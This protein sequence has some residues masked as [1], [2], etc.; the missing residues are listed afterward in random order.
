MRNLKINKIDLLVK[1][2]KIS[3]SIYEKYNQKKVDEIV[4]AA[5]W[6][7]L[8][9]SN[10]IYLSKLAV[11][12]TGLGRTEDKFLK[13]RNK[14][15][16]LLR[17]LKNIKTVG[18][19]KKDKKKGIIEIAKPVG[20]IASLTPATNPIATP[21]NNIL[22]SLKCR[23]SIIVSPSPAGQKVFKKMIQFINYELS[24]VKA[25]KNL[26]QTFKSKVNADK[27]KY[28]M[29]K[30]DLV[31]VTGAQHNVRDAYSS[32]TPALGVGKGNPSIIIDETANLLKTADLIKSSKTFDNGTSC[33][34][35]SN[36]IIMN[37]VYKK[38]LKIL[39]SKGGFLLNKTQETK[40]KKKLW[41]KGSLNRNLVAKPPDIILKNIDVN[42]KNQN[43]IRFIITQE[44]RI[45]KKFPLSGEKISPI[46]NLYKA[47][48]FEGAKKIL[49]KILTYQGI[50]HSVGIHTKKFNKVLELGNEMP[51]CRVINNQ[52]HAFAAGGSFS[53]GLQFTLS[54]GCGTW[55]KNSIDVNLNYKHFLNITKIVKPIKIK[56][57]KLK[58]FFRDY[59]KRYDPKSL[60]FLID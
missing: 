25:P 48:N 51:V 22:N 14:T 34:S 52:A 29:K 16:G 13:N 6:A 5:A 17:D 57:Y 53:N 26:I 19:I 60:K 39:I 24:K 2:A 46:L 58:D 15:I 20:V 37:K 43:E 7:V 31:I 8:K 36:L 9:P 3:Q 4:N 41:V 12:S 54:L 44:K 50:G 40:L 10:N 18:I 30:V 49:K 33:S 11:N 35:E 59:C 27:T 21:L 47:K 56:Q 45:G 1:N 42:I 23:N 55:G 32:G 38:F 28:L